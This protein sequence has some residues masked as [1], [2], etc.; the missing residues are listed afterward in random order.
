MNET[1]ETDEVYLGSTT[2]EFS[3][4]ISDVQARGLQHCALELAGASQA[5]CQWV[6]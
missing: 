4:A 5:A 1:L 3:F 6:N 2:H